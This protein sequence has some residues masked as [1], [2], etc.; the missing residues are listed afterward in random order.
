MKKARRKKKETMVEA[1]TKGGRHPEEEAL[2]PEEEAFPNA[3][4]RNGEG[5]TKGGPNPTSGRAKAWSRVQPTKER[6]L[7]EKPT[8]APRE[9][10]LK[11]P[12]RHFLTCRRR[13]STTQRRPL[14]PKKRRWRWRTHRR[15]CGNR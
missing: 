6:R 13:S 9:A 12:H 3:P 2:L 7:R 5:L 4:H 8:R 10:T 1:T 11:M 15:P 14:L